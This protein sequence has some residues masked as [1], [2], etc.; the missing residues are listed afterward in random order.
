ML[1][2]LIHMVR[3]ILE[4]FEVEFPD[5]FNTFVPSTD[6][7]PLYHAIHGGDHVETMR[8][9]MNRGGSILVNSILCRDVAYYARSRLDDKR[10]VLSISMFLAE[11]YEFKKMKAYLFPDKRRIWSIPFLSV[12]GGVTSEMQRK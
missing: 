1:S 9:R 11:E 12:L 2:I 3:M 7:S 4:N 8:F 10:T 6:D 5:Y